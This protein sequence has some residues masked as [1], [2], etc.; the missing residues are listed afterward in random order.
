MTMKPCITCGEPCD[1]P[2]CPDHALPDHRGTAAAR[3]YDSRW[4]RLS[5]RARKL[6]PFCSDCG[7]TDDLTVDHSTEAWQRYE[8][9]LTIRLSDVEVV[10]RAC[11]S[12]RGAA[13]PRGTAL[14]EGA[15]R[16]ADKAQFQ[17]V[18]RTITISDERRDR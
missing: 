5:K 9:N 6:Q 17:L 14:E 13:R 12:R 4:R 10:C 16:P 2:R 15:R 18:M 8:Q 3:G 11:N 7:T 1:G